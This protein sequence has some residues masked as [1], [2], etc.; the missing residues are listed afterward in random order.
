[1][2][3][4][5]GILDQLDRRGMSASDRHHVEGYVR[6]DFEHYEDHSMIG[7]LPGFEP[8]PNLRAGVRWTFSGCTPD[9]DG[10]AVG[11]YVEVELVIPPLNFS[12]LR[13]LQELLKQQGPQPNQ[14]QMLDYTISTVELALR[15]N[16][17]GVPRWLI[18]ETLDQASAVEIADQLNELSGVVSKKTEESAPPNSTGTNSSAGS[19]MSPETVGTPSSANGISPA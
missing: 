17:R 5:T 8:L 16:Y 9:A 19:S 13:A 2:S 11:E 3:A 12:A 4:D 14:A 1:M 15:R 10:I 18:E 7:T 6:N